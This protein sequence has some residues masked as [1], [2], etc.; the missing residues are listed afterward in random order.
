MEDAK[1]ATDIAKAQIELAEAVA[2]IQTITK[3]RDRLHK[4]GL[5]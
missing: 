4:T 3:L 2:Q 1:T 5:A